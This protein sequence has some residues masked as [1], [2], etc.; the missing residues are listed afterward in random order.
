MGVCVYA[1]TYMCNTHL[2]DRGIY[3]YI[4]RININKR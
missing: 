4:S 1:I 2:F 3:I